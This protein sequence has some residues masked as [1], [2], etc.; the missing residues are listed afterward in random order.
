[1]LLIKNEMLP[2][3]DVMP[4]HYGADLSLMLPAQ[5]FTQFNKNRQIKA[6][7]YISNA[8]TKH[9]S[10]SGKQIALRKAE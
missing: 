3:L 1:M 7:R 5:L 2:G 6:N 4:N 8:T 10:T 9:P